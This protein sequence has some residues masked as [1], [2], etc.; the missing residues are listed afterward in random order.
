MACSIVSG[1]GSCGSAELEESLQ[2]LYGNNELAKGKALDE[3][4]AG[5]ATP[6]SLARDAASVTESLNALY[7]NDE[8]AKEKAKADLGSGRIT[9]SGLTDKARADLNNL[10]RITGGDLAKADAIKDS[11]SPEVR[12]ELYRAF[13]QLPPG[14]QEAYINDAVRLAR[15]KDARTATGGELTEEEIR[16]GLTLFGG[17]P[18]SVAMTAPMGELGIMLQTSG[19]SLVAGPG[20]KT[21]AALVGLALGVTV[22]VLTVQMAP[23]PTPASPF[24]G[25]DSDDDGLISIS[26][27]TGTDGSGSNGSNNDPD[28][29]KKLIPAPPF[30]VHP[31]SQKNPDGVTEDGQQIFND[32]AGNR[33]IEEPGTNRRVAVDGAGRISVQIDAKKFDYLFGRA[34]GRDHNIDRTKQNVAEMKRLGIPDNPEGYDMITRHL[35][36]AVQNKS[37]VTK[38]FSNEWGTF[39][40]RQSLFAGPSGK[41]SIFES[42]WQVLPSG[43]RRFSTLISKG[44][45]K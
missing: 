10:T 17:L 29:P 24:A 20:G 15:L 14:S 36:D 44:G 22:G 31:G 2:Q 12:A 27:S 11:L 43:E 33:W 28:D 45:K 39:E 5:R 16:L 23:A 18:R 4:N 41:F 6:S 9:I 30:D 21:P 35:S 8:A 38:T 34:G 25:P 26:P 37:N 42:T 7:G 1:S 13:D 40:V 3:I 19:R 32:G